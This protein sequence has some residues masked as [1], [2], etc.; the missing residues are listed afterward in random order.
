MLARLSAEVERRP[1][2]KPRVSDIEYLPERDADN[3]VLVWRP[4]MYVTEPPSRE[5]LKAKEP[6]DKVNGIHWAKVNKC[7]GIAR[8]SG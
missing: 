7:K 3:I 8:Q 1:D 6:F 2:H 5:D 4:R